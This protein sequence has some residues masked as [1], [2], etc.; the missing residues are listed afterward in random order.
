MNYK[1]RKLYER[2]TK[3]KLSELIKRDEA[4]FGFVSSYGWTCSKCVLDSFNAMRMQG[5]ELPDS[6]IKAIEEWLPKLKC[7]C[8]PNDDLIKDKEGLLMLREREEDSIAIYEHIKIHP[9]E[10]E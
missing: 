5:I 6:T 1:E 8:V 10:V 9:S 4:G 3:R 2:I 7:E